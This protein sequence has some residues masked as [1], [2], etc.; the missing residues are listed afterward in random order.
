VFVL[1]CKMP[2]AFFARYL[3]W[4]ESIKQAGRISL[5]AF[6]VKQ[7]FSPASSRIAPRIR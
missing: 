7:S 5:E 4:S 3:A 1:V 6:Q 2:G